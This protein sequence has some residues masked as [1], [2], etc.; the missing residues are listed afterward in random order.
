[1][2]DRYAGDVGDFGEFALL[3]ALATRR[4]LGVCWYRCSGAR[5]QNNDGRHIAYLRR[6]ER[7]RHLDAEVFDAMA[8]VVRLERSLRA[9]EACGLLPGATYHGEEVPYRRD[10]RRAWFSRMSRALETCDLVF[11][12]VDNGFEWSALTP[13]CIAREEVR[14]PTSRASRR[15]SPRPEPRAARPCA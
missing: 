8:E 7:F 6:P 3:R 1:M 10:H 5:E 9:L 11:A 14:R 13:K 4:E 2:Q 15:G 12:D